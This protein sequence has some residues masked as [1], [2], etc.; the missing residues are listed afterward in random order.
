MAKTTL[1]ASRGPL[2]QLLDELSGDHGVEMLDMLKRLQRKELMP[3]APF[4]SWGPLII[5]PRGASESEA[6][7]QIDAAGMSFLYEWIPSVLARIPPLSFEHEEIYDL[8]RVSASQ[9][10]FSEIVPYG[11]VIDHAV[12]LGLGLCPANLALPLRISYKKQPDMERLCIG[13]EP[14]HTLAAD[15][16]PSGVFT[17]LGRYEHTYG[18]CLG[19]SYN[20][21]RQNGQVGPEDEFVFIC[22]NK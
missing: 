19:M 18:T 14:V 1:S 20:L 6:K 15:G 3:R 17:L 22:P 11:D 5:D 4:T 8:V 12:N 16:V 9:L 10:G 13:M 2:K 21:S 7:K